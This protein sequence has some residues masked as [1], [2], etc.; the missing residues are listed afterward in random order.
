MPPPRRRLFLGLTALALAAS[1]PLRAQAPRVYR[2]GVLRPTAPGGDETMSTGLV[3]EVRELGYAEGRNLA[4]E[5][6]YA[7]N[8]LNRL[9]ALAQELVAPTST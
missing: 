7:D 8:K 4:I 3:R 5:Y 2:I 1:V 6:R 9:P